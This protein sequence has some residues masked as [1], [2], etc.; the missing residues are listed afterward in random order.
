MA[1]SYVSL[2]LSGKKALFVK[3]QTKRQLVTITGRPILL[4]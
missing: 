1:Q 2:I 3:V 4:G